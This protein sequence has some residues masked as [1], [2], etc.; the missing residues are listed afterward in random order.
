MSARCLICGTDVGTFYET[1]GTFFEATGNYGSGVFDPMSPWF[2]LL[3]AVCD[4]CMTTVASGRIA[5]MEMQRQRP[6]HSVS[7]WSAPIPEVTP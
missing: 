2:R 1:T 7:T 5:L 6:T 3:A 4:E